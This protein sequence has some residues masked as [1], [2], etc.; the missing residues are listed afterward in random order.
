MAIAAAA[1]SPRDPNPPA[2]P[3][4]SAV[5]TQPPRAAPDMQAV[6]DQL[7]QLGASPSSS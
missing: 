6:L 4:P 2:P 7:Q 1:Q 5:A 3:P